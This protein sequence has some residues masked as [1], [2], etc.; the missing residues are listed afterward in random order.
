MEILDVLRALGQ[1]YTQIRL[2]LT[3]SVGLH[4]ILKELKEG[5][6]PRFPPKYNGA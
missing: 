2:V 4:H 6:L 3:G 1:D 5:R